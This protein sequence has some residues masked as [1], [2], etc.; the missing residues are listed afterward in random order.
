M[1]IRR[2]Y[3]LTR[4]RFLRALRA[5][6][7]Y[8]PPE[9]TAVIEFTLTEA[10]HLLDHGEAGIGLEMLI[11]NLFEVGYQAPPTLV[12]DLRWLA[13]RLAIEP[14][15]AAVIDQLSHEPIAA[16][17]PAPRDSFLVACRFLLS[18]TGIWDCR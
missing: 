12:G 7:R 10:R 3:K 15:C 18:H 5:V 9:H 14:G 4:F 13:T 1:A 8:Y 6:R 11:C 17:V 2:G 16:P